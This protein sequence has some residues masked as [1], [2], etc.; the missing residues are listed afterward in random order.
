[1]WI[2][3][4][5]T[6]FIFVLRPPILLRRMSAIVGPINYFSEYFWSK[7]SKIFLRGLLVCGTSRRYADV[8]TNVQTV[9]RLVVVTLKV[10]HKIK[11][12][13]TR[14]SLLLVLQPAKTNRFFFF[15]SISIFNTLLVVCSINRY[16][17][18]CRRSTSM[19]LFLHRSG[20][21]TATSSEQEGMPTLYFRSR[22]TVV[23]CFA[24]L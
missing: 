12:T 21:Q 17:F 22:V 10:K 11:N 15:D 7:R 8:S 20:G 5:F 24:L 3:S 14:R 23:M 13:T 1:M 16:S 19:R 9:V 2:Q 18:S 6:C 4:G